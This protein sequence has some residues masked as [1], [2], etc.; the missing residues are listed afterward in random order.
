MIVMES[1]ISSRADVKPV[2]LAFIG[3]GNRAGKYLSWVEAHPRRAVAVAVADLD[4]ARRE[5]FARRAGIA[6]EATFAT[7]EDLF[8]SPVE[9]DAAVICT[10]E[11]VHFAP[12]MEALERGMDILLEKPVSPSLEECLT[13]EAA[14]AEKG[15]VAG[16]CHVLRYH[17]YFAALR[18]LISSRELG[19][20]VSVTHRVKV[21]IDRACH[22]FVRGPWGDT[23]MTSPVIL[24]KCCHDVDLL[25]WMLGDKA[26]RVES[27][28]SQRWFR[29]ENKPAEAAGRCIDCPI[30]EECRFSAVDLYRRRGEW[31]GGF[32]FPTR[33]EAVER[34]LREGRYGRCV[35]ACGN[36]AADRQMIL[37]ETERGTIVSLTMDFFT[38]DD[39]RHTTITLTGGEI[40]GDGKKITVTPFIGKERVIDFTDIVA[41]PFHAGADMA[42]MD[43]F[44]SAVANPAH[45]MRSGISDAIESHRVCLEAEKSRNRHGAEPSAPK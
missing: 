44:V 19:E 26:A 15:S 14:A 16:V 38:T 12:A 25:L 3:A 34:E 1:S 5:A 24:S 33:A 21:G 13:I 6:P 42:L 31:T 45:R 30:E 32:T 20:P 40:T 27:M 37:M 10:P 18:S 7:A 23:S 36:D 4:P 22:T 43:D 41:Q 39:S 2:R 11:G 8:A 9:A 28:G 17:P 29:P 35:Y